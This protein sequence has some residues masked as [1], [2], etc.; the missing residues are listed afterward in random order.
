MRSVRVWRAK[1]RVCAVR[2]ASRIWVPDS[3]ERMRLIWALKSSMVTGRGAMT[4]ARPMALA[5]GI[6]AETKMGD[7]VRASGV[8]SWLMSL[9]DSM[10]ASRDWGVLSPG[11]RKSVG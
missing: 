4:F 6:G 11:D 1:G 8:V 7:S 10:T 2:T 3:L 5:C 9:G